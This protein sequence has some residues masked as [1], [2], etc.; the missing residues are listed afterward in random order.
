MRIALI[1]REYPP[2]T[3]WGGIGTHY[4]AFAAGLRDAGCEVE[5]FTQGLH[6]AS[7]RKQDGLLV[8]RVLPRTRAVG[9]RRGG[10][11]AGGSL[12][13]IGLFSLALAR[14]F[15]KAFYARHEGAAFN[16]V[17]SHEHLG[18]SSL[19]LR[20]TNPDLLT[21]TRYQTPYDSIVTR[22]MANWPRS[23]LVRWLENMAINKAR[24]RV[25]TSHSIEFIVRRDFPSAP[26][27]EE[28]IPNL[29]GISFTG[30]AVTP[31]DEREPLMLFVGRLMPGHKNP[32]HAAEVFR[33]I[34]ADYPDWRIEFAGSDIPLGDNA[35]MW[36][37]CEEILRSY[38]GRYH[39]HGMLESDAVRQLYRSARI[40]IVPSRIESYGLVA[41]EAMSN[42]CVPLVAD[43]TA[44]PEVVGNGGLVFENG[45]IDSL[46]KALRQL[47]DNEELCRQCQQ[48]GLQR[49]QTEL[50]NDTIIGMNIALYER[51]LA[52]IRGAN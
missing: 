24:V 4:A 28:I 46:E 27:A 31:I 45:N 34:S 3:S 37:R 51:E 25:A 33:R 40:L 22:H 6:E 43:K 15:A 2:E 48:A 18:V 44:L 42:G 17:D 12:N 5:V 26:P 30:E 14:E 13:T 41:L 10:E 52:K 50:S 23:R 16:V 35:T 11:L 9:A 20:R 47:L 49:V 21:V 32:D 29:S 19:I 39:Y 7:S 8:H 1:T 36:G 38:P